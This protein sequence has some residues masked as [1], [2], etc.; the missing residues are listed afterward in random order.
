[1]IRHKGRIFFYLASLVILTSISAVLLFNSIL[2]L[3]PKVRAD[4]TSQIKEKI[5]LVGRVG[6]VK[7]NIHNAQPILELSQVELRN[8]QY[9]KGKLEKVRISVSLIKSLMNRR[10]VVS[11][12]KLEDGDLTLTKALSAKGSKGTGRLSGFIEPEQIRVKLEDIKIR[13]A[14]RKRPINIKKLYFKGRGVK[15]LDAEVEFENSPIKIKTEF[16][17]SLLDWKTWSGFS[18]IKADD[19]KTKVLK[20]YI[21]VKGAPNRMSGEYWIDFDE[22]DFSE[23]QSRFDLDRVQTPLGVFTDVKGAGSIEKDDDGYQVVFQNLFFKQGRSQ[24]FQKHIKVQTDTAYQPQ[25]IYV[26]GIDL[27]VIPLITKQYREAALLKQIKKGYLKLL[28][29]ERD[30][31]NQWKIGLD[32]E[33]VSFEY[34]GNKVQ[35][36]TGQLVY[37]NNQ[38]NLALDSQDIQYS[39]KKLKYKFPHLSTHILAVQK[40]ASWKVVG[41]NNLVHI[42]ASKL[43]FDF[44]YDEN[45]T[46]PILELALDGDVRDPKAIVAEINKLQYS[47]NLKRWLRDAL[48]SSGQLKI[49]G[50]YRGPIKDITFGKNATLQIDAAIDKLDLNY[51][52]GWP[53][54]YQASGLI[55]MRDQKL[56]AAIKQAKL[57]HAP[58]KDINVVLPDVFADDVHVLLKGDLNTALPNI[59]SFINHSP[60]KNELTALSKM[61]FLGE[62]RLK[63]DLD[64]PLSNLPTRLNGS[65][66]V[67]KAVLNIP[68]WDL[69]VKDL[70]SKIEFDEKGFSA[71]SATGKLFDHHVKGY[72]ERTKRGSI[73]HIKGKG[74]YENFLNYFQVERIKKVIKGHFDYNAQVVIEKNRKTKLILKYQPKA[75][76]SEFKLPILTDLLPEQMD[77]T[78]GDDSIETVKLT[79]KNESLLLRKKQDNYTL[80]GKVGTLDVDQVIKLF[81]DLSKSKKKSPATLNASLDIQNL[82]YHKNKF[83][84][85]KVK[86]EERTD[87]IRVS[88]FSKLLS[89]A[90]EILPDHYHVFLDYLKLNTKGSEAA[91]GSTIEITQPVEFKINSLVLDNRSI[92]QLA[93]DIIPESN[94]IEIKNGRL[95]QGK[96]VIKFKGEWDNK[97]TS[98]KGKYDIVDIK[99][100]LDLFDAN[101]LIV[102]KK[103]EGAFDLTWRGM[104][105]Q[106]EEEKLR[107][108]VKLALYNGF[109]PKLDESVERKL[110]LAKLI[111]LLSFSSI[112]RK[113]SLDFS[114]IGRHGLDFSTIDSIL[115]FNS[116]TL[117]VKKLELDGN[118]LFVKVMGSLSLVNKTFNLKLHV[119]PYVTSSLPTIATIA[120]GPL[121]GVATWVA[122]KAVNSII[123]KRPLYLYQVSGP[124]DDPV[125]KQLKETRR[126]RRGGTGRR[127]G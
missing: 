107:G 62:G 121:A 109:I 98:I 61:Q 108:Q 33:D 30:P 15:H 113:L 29:L 2:D 84:K 59:T 101:G 7:I 63:I 88:L 48:D 69:I 127:P 122:N 74:T 45:G 49:K 102:S 31:A 34:K 89:G 123:Q 19:F 14:A 67:K 24:Y 117:S 17:G 81:N 119:N 47:R 112:A 75:V 53:A 124:W 36:A 39:Y 50:I 93:F 28:R 97:E 91:M 16:T 110:G 65:I 106:V 100:F 4:L 86:L 96:S 73:I 25:N 126:Y 66:D 22:G 116:G 71:R 57:S 83:K 64:I 77:I 26:S 37:L 90:L 105:W 114:D 78:L 32:F 38:L 52:T 43:G 23:I 12:V 82:I 11:G 115:L 125:I 10:P 5:A 120:G 41:R 79:Q 94:Y 6:Q 103:A 99:P 104:P 95:R 42:G 87:F 60:L 58:I 76:E 13:Y 55:Q 1:M 118:T 21:Q 70:K 20:P 80:T 44:V 54:A 27:A 18:Y 9:V 56:S 92:G 68:E 35:H 85:V 111:N 3:F 72:V 8:N 51:K 40:N 46:S